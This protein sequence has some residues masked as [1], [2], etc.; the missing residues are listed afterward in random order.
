M[1]M[2]QPSALYINPQK[3]QIHATSHDGDLQFES[4]TTG[5]PYN[6][7]S[8]RHQ[9]WACLTPPILLASFVSMRFGQLSNRSIAS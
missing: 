9:A 5:D 7:L 6:S 8:L 4:V 2:G 1:A 3:F